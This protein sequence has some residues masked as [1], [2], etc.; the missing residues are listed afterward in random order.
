MKNI[1][2]KFTFEVKIQ[3]GEC[4][5][6]VLVDLISAERNTRIPENE[7]YFEYEYQPRDI[8]KYSEDE[9]SEI[10]DEIEKYEY[11]NEEELTE[12]APL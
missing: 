11:D 10:W 12:Y 5:K 7:E 3:T 2:P 8:E 9:I 6:T 4:E 1:E